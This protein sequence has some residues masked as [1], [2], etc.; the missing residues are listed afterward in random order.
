MD[1]SS[2]PA[3]ATPGNSLTQLIDRFSTMLLREPDDRSEL[4]KLL[5]GAHERNLVDAEALTI[6]EGALTVS[7]MTVRD[8]MVPRQQ[9]HTLSATQPL[10]QTIRKVIDSGHSRLPVIGEEDD[11]VRGI[12]LAKDLLRSIGN[13]NFRLEDWLRP[14]MFIPESK[15]LNVLLREFRI[16]HTHMA[17]VIDE[18]GS[19]A[20]L[21]TI[22]DV[23]EEIVGEIEDE[24]DQAQLDTDIQLD[25]SGRYRVK[26]QTPV[27]R[28]NEAFSTQFDDQDA[29]TLG[30]Q[31][32]HYLGRV[33]RRN[34]SVELNGLLFRV[35]RADNRRLYSLMVEVLEPPANNE[36]TQQEELHNGDDA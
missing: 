21:V 27:D 34:E 9:M 6:I 13:S 15:P 36:N 12:I 24:H 35:I 3:R 16:S 18:F 2:S 22:E 29:H 23:L 5:H 30:G 14:A 7:E 8:I 28:F 31:I 10:A 20:G 26:A 25:A 19:L 32:V 4:L 11:D 17:L 1:P 33:P